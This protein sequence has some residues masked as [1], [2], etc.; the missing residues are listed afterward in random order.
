ME[1]QEILIEELVHKIEL[2]KDIRENEKFKKQK[3]I[4]NLA[5]KHLKKLAIDKLNKRVGEC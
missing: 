1:N 3:K 4:Y 2:D 5:V